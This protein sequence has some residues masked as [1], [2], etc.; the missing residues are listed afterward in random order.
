MRQFS[1]FLLDMGEGKL[2]AYPSIGEDIVRVP[3]DMLSHSSGPDEL[4]QEIFG[5]DP[6]R[7]K[8]AEFM[9]PCAILTPRNLDV[10]A[11]N[12]KATDHLNFPGVVSCSSPLIPM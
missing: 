2:Q 10:D 6:S 1:R 12:D 4:I 9:V 11:I 7:M 5:D 8:D 3:D